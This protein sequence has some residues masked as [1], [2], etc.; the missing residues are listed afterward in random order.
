MRLTAAIGSVPHEGQPSP[1]APWA[2]VCGASSCGGTQVSTAVSGGGSD[3]GDRECF[4]GWSNR[5][6]EEGFGGPEER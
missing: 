4:T 1:G 6:G 2:A 5:Q 3:A